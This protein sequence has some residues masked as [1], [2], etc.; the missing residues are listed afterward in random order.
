MTP[1]TDLRDLFE[2]VGD[3][4]DADAASGQFAHQL[5][6]PLGLL[7]GQRGSRLVHD[8]DAHLSGQRLGDLDHLLLGDPQGADDPQGIDRRA[9]PVQEFLRL[10]HEHAPVDDSEPT[11]QLPQ[12]QVLGD[13]E[14]RNE[15]QLLVDR[16]DA[17]SLGVGGGRDARKRT[18]DADLSGVGL[19]D[20]P[21]HLDEGALARAVLP[22]EDVHFGL[23]QVEV[24]PGQRHHP[25]IGLAD[26]RHHKK[27]G[28]TSPFVT[29]R[30]QV[31]VPNP[32]R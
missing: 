26:A 18:V 11:G 20:P 4:D 19:H 8:E 3:E 22:E 7:T 28:H 16:C 6:Q 13:A 2:V 25:G 9:D 1:A 21:E 17:P 29:G 14:L 10:A 15:R 12:E 5:E 23:A 24:D 31:R 27:L 30:R 32:A